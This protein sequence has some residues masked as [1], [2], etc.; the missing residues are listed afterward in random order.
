LSNGPTWYPGIGADEEIAKLE[1][2][3][4]QITAF[5][6]KVE[7]ELFVIFMF[8]IAGDSLNIFVDIE[9]CRAVFFSF[10]S[11]EGKMRMLHNAMCARFRNDDRTLNDWRELRKACISLAGLRNE[12]AHL[13][14]CPKYSA[15]PRAIATVRLRPPFW[16]PSG[17]ADFED[18]G[19]SW[20]EL[21][22]AL[23][24]FWGYDPTLNIPPDVAKRLT[25]RIHQFGLGLKPPSPS[26]ETPAPTP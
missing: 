7:D 1:R 16:K 24:P 21:T 18:Q 10:S 4:G 22:Q 13:I 23:R 3:V 17:G 25:F 9:P 12:I 19:Y 6:A 2:L 14:A 8:A 26:P 15:D 20:N 11:F 5:W